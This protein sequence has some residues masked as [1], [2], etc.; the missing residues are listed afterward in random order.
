MHIHSKPERNPFKQNQTM[1]IFGCIALDWLCIFMLL[2]KEIERLKI[3]MYSRLPHFRLALVIDLLLLH[4]HH[5]RLLLNYH[6]NR[7]CHVAIQDR[8]KVFQ[9][10]DSATSVG[11]LRIKLMFSFKNIVATMSLG[12]KDD[13]LGAMTSFI[14][15]RLYS[16]SN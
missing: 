16:Y 7:Q 14:P 12:L 10:K 8:I 9:I 6:E 1:Y 5:H 11:L 13:L 15:P 3:K 4:R 2:H